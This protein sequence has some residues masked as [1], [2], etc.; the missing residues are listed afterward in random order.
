MNKGSAGTTM[1]GKQ[2][3]IDRVD[4]YHPDYSERKNLFKNKIM[5]SFFFNIMFTPKYDETRD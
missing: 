5:I 2:I 1:K 4:L 3:C